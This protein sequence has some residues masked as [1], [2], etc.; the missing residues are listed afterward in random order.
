MII[1]CLQFAQG[2]LR[3]VYNQLKI[4]AYVYNKVCC[5]ISNIRKEGKVRPGI[6]TDLLLDGYA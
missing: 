1:L 2:T 3:F 5:P 6:E 4:H